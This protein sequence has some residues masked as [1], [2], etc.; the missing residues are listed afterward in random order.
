MLP[1]ALVVYLALALTPETT[2]IIG[3]AELDLMDE[4]AWLVNV[5]RGPHIDTDAL[6]AALNSGS[7]AGAALDVT[8]PEPLPDGH[9]LWDLPNC[10]ITPHTADTIE[11]VMPL[12]A[13]RIRTNVIR[14]AAGEPLVGVVDPDA[15]Y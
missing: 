13:E 8:D 6:V 14:F 5:A 7:I 15:G 11:M 2:G 4:P 9:P 1:G 3:A 12:L 10:I